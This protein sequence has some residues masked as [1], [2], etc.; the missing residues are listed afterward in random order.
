MLG[1]ARRCNS[2]TMQDI[3]IIIRVGLYGTLMRAP[4]LLKCKITKTTID[5]DMI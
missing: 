1:S 2:K 3:T 5:N 4:G